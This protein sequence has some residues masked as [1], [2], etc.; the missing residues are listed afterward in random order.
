MKLAAWA[1]VIYLA[2]VGGAEMYS[3]FATASPTADMIKALPSA[4]SLLSSTGTTA[5]A[6]DFGAAAALWFFV[7]K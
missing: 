1:A 4:G 6:L 2:A 7:I 5:A 3:G